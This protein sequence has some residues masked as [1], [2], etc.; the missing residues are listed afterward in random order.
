MS[1]IFSPPDHIKIPEFNFDD[2]QGYQDA[3]K[4]CIEELK[5]WVI[6]RNPTDKYVGKILK[7]PAADGYA[8]YMV[9]ATKPVELIHLPLGD[10]WQFQYANRLTKKD[11]VEKIDAE[12]AFAKKYPRNA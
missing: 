5:A 2:I 12:E 11:I 10:A 9:A 7:F 8:M 3:E 4:A 6:K 1:K